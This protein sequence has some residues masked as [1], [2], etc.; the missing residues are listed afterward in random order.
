[1]QSANIRPIHYLGSKLRIM[2]DIGSVV[3]KLDPYGG[4]ICDLFSGSGTVSGYFRDKR[5][6]T[7]IDIQEYSKILCGAVL[8]SGLEKDVQLSDII[9]GKFFEKS[10]SMFSPLVQYECECLELLKNGTYEPMYDLI[11]N[12]S[13]YASKINGFKG[14]RPLN[15]CLGT[16]IENL[17]KSQSWSSDYSITILYG[18]LYFSF[19]QAI[20][21]DCIR[22]YINNNPDSDERNILYAS[23]MGAT[24]DIVNTVG[25]QFAQP[26]RVINS[27][28][29]LKKVHRNK[30][31]NDRSENIYEHFINWTN[32]YKKLGQVNYGHECIC[33]DYADVLDNFDKDYFSVIY[34]DPPYTRYHYSRY[35]HI[36]ETIA[37]NDFPQITTT[38]END[39]RISRGMYR[40]NRYQSPFCIESKAG[41]AFDSLFK[42]VSRFDAPFILSYSPYTDKK[43]MT[44]RMQTIN[45]LIDLGKRYYRKVELRNVSQI[46]HS[47]LNE[48]EKNHAIDY[49]AEKLIVCEE[50][51]R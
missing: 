18:G 2:D 8:S 40:A 7:S 46:A 22:H 30:I 13:I 11:E 20:G 39:S 44:P 35:Y 50:P 23:L 41:R 24:S 43:T 27:Q 29:E 15:N 10:T 47:R 32:E 25:K 26:L 21:I 48:K 33:G 37:K 45:E 42:K 49:D 36:L 9:N 28:G 14:S 38:F 3:L 17:E 34:A 16:V 1:M 31:I 5:P 12:G 51:K 19:E 6:V 4:R